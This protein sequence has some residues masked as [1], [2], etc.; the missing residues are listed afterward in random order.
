[1]VAASWLLNHHVVSRHIYAACALTVVALVVGLGRLFANPATG[2]A[3]RRVM[4]F[5]ITLSLGST[6]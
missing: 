1:V 3:R 5:G 4:P 2:G 6:V